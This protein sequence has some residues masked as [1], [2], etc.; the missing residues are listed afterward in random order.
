MKLRI[1]FTLFLCIILSGCSDDFDK[2]ERKT[3]DIATNIDNNFYIIDE[4]EDD[5]NDIV[6]EYSD[7]LRLTYAEYTFSNSGCSAM[8]HYKNDY[9]VHEKNYIETIDLYVN[10]SGEAYK[11]E[12]TD[13]RIN[14]VNDYP[15]NGIADKKIDVLELFKE[16]GKSFIDDNSYIKVILNEKGIELNYYTGDSIV[17][18]KRIES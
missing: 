2:Y 7:K 4:I 3:I 13:G 17:E 18:R 14:R 10:S 6:T 8:F 5:L 15:S 11:I 12:Y 1:I 16:N 9:S